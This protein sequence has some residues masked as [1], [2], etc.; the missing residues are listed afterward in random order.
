MWISRQI[1]KG[2]A[3]FS[4]ETGKVTLSSK[5]TIETVSTGVDRDVHIYTPYGYSYLPPAG[6]DMLLTKSSGEQAGIGVS[7]Q[8]TDVK[9]GEIKIQAQSGAYIHFKENG[10]V[11]I[12]GIEIDRDGVL[13]E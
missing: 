12:N 6:A 8:K 13:H 5:S 4:A 1:G 9:N 2:Q 10:S 3:N 7:M 11:V